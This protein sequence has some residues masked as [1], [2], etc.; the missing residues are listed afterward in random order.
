V[1][2]C[3]DAGQQRPRGFKAVVPWTIFDQDPHHTCVPQIPLSRCSATERH[4]PGRKQAFKCWPPAT[5]QLDFTSD[6]QPGYALPVTLILGMSKPE[7]IYLSVDY[8]VT[9]YRTGRLIDDASIKSLTIHYPPLAKGGPKVLLGFT[10]LAILPDGTPTLTWI[11]QTLRGE[12]EIINQSMA[13]LRARL[14]RDIG[15]QRVPLIIDLLV[16]EKDRRFFGGF[17]NLRRTPQG[18]PSVMRNFQYA[19]NELKDWTI[20]ASGSGGERI[21][22]D[23][24]LDR[25]KPHLAIV[26]REPM[27]HMNLLAVVNRRVAAKDRGVSPFCHVSFV[28]SDD[29]FRPASH[30]FTARGEGVP[31]EMPFLLAGLDATEIV[32]DFMRDSQ[33]IFRGEIAALPVRDNEQLN[34]QTKRRP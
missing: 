27:N 22:K 5:R 24:H 14:D 15:P 13:H 7:G 8:R 1:L 28:N 2:T 23:G 26:P 33:A 25:L 9:D 19:M 31:F 21:L 10:G 11:R 17:T 6:S 16:L 32:R 4:I 3:E 12:S 30:S 20:F 34:E 18:R 29:R